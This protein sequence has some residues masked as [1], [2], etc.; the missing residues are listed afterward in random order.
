MLV[1][2][3]LAA[4][5]FLPALTGS[6]TNWDDDVNITANPHVR[7]GGDGLVALLSRPYL[8]LYLPVTYGI[9]WAGY[10]L[11][12]AGGGGYH[13]LNLLGH[14]AS[15]ALLYS[16]LRAI[17]KMRWPALLAAGWWAVH[18]INVE[19]VAW[20]T[21]LKDVL[22]V[23]F[24]LLSWRLYIAWRGAAPSALRRQ[25][26]FGAS[27]LAFALACLSKPGVVLFPAVLAAY[28]LLIER[29]KARELAPLALFLA[30][31]LLAG[32]LTLAIHNPSEAGVAARLG[33]K[34]HAALAA[35]SGI[36]Y[37]EKSSWPA[38]LCP[39][40]GR[41]VRDALG[42]GAEFPW[43]NLAI[44]VAIGIL[45]LWGGARWKLAAVL[46]VAAVAPVSGI[47]AFGYQAYSTVADRYAYLPAAGLAL[48]LG[49]L[50][51]RSKVREPHAHVKDAVIVGLIGVWI[52]SLGCLAW[53]QSGVW[54]NSLTLW[55][56]VIECN[57]APTAPVLANY[58][59]ALFRANRV[60]EAIDVLQR[61]V[62]ARPGYVRGRYNLARALQAAG[63][64]DAARVHYDYV[65]QCE[66]RH[67]NALLALGA[68]EASLRRYGA[69]ADLCRQALEVEPQ[70]P[71][72]GLNLG[73]AL[74]ELNQPEEAARALQEVVTT[75]PR[76]YTARY[77]LGLAC[78]RTGRLDQARAQFLAIAQAPPGAVDEPLRSEA[79]RRLGN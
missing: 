4:I 53:M 24:V 65:L 58:G 69:C 38:G 28:D 17:L 55:S 41:T 75:H 34:G 64:F 32:A 12:G 43:V 42:T 8:R 70:D 59:S 31:A 74:L 29:R 63:Q 68:L 10:H 22:S 77:H 62:D 14:L 79:N 1:L 36:F 3:V 21:G 37:L 61:A 13:A 78:S 54:K 20:I 11:W 9:W 60:D 40:Y 45:V 52:V 23:L 25:W 73:L 46:F 16:I 76:D 72:A 47:V 71:T 50:L 2:C 67:L 35:D 18:P 57:P 7:G 44:I 51:E 19:P 39:V 48:I 30:P 27:L 66:P 15:V 33:W 26:L 56:R 6:L 5:P 49:D